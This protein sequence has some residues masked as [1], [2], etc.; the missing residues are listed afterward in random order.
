MDEV[1]NHSLSSPAVFAQPGTKSS[2]NGW[3]RPIDIPVFS[4]PF[5]IGT[6]NQNSGDVPS[7]HLG[8][9]APGG[10][11]HLL[12]FPYGLPG[13]YRI[14]YFLV[15]PS[16]VLT[17]AVTEIE[18][19]AIRDVERTE[20]RFRVD[21]RIQQHNAVLLVDVAWDGPEPPP[22]SSCEIDAISVEMLELH[23]FLEPYGE[24]TSKM[25]TWSPE[26]ESVGT[27]IVLPDDFEH[28]LGTLFE[29][30]YLWKESEILEKFLYL[31]SEFSLDILQASLAEV[32]S[33]S[34]GTLSSEQRALEILAYVTQ[35]MYLSEPETRTKELRL[36]EV[37]W[38][39]GSFWLSQ[40]W[41][42]CYYRSL[43][44]VSLC[45]AAG[46]PAR[47]VGLPN[48]DHVM[49]ETYFDG[50]WHLLDP[51][52]G[53]FYYTHDTYDGDGKILSLR[54]LRVSGN[55][56]SPLF[57][58]SDDIWIGDFRAGAIV[59]PVPDSWSS[60]NAWPVTNGWMDYY[61][62]GPLITFPC[63]TPYFAGFSRAR[64]L[65]FDFADGD[66]LQVG[67]PDGNVS[68][69]PEVGSAGPYNGV[70]ALFFQHA[71]SGRYAVTYK[72]LFDDVPHI[73]AA[74]EVW[75]IDVVSSTLYGGGTWQLIIDVS[76]PNAI[77][78][79]DQIHGDND[80]Q[81][82]VWAVDAIHVSRL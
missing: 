60:P 38:H 43:A 7:S 35:K 76:D 77:L 68:D 54:D 67:T 33:L 48:M 45:R 69:A 1:L 55:P 3:F 29:K 52:Y 32:F 10:A 11:I 81:D 26:L 23:P 72:F 44:F 78:F 5:W 79:V 12:K 31:D 80:F 63:S 50:A 6:V 46:L 51:T 65:R 8:S 14:T 41:G 56:L 64:P 53:F 62:T 71:P 39:T 24:L 18:D 61:R 37:P 49:A 17:P 82:A 13:I 47:V 66:S 57:K 70:N 20:G 25:A 21:C 22:A 58:V 16:A 9:S 2:G 34:S 15:D 42:N 30:G 74:V 4:G 40:G 19:V 36:N 28:S 59:S 75:G 27:P 73:P